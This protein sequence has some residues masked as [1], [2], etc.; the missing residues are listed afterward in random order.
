LIEFT[1]ERV[2]PG[3]VDPD[4]WNEHVA[5]YEF[6]ARLAEGRRVL[7]AGC[8][9][10]YGSARL[11]EVARSVV[12]V[13]SAADAIGYALR[14][15]AA[16]NLCFLQASCEALPLAS[17]SRDL[18]TAFEVIEHL[19]DWRAFL[20]EVERVLAPGGL[21]VI[22]TPNTDY[23]AESR[24]LTGP[25]PYHVH[26]FDFAGFAEALAARFPHVSLY[27]E[28]HVAAIAFEPAGGA[29]EGPVAL[30]RAARGTEAGWPHFFLA[31]CGASA[32]PEPRAFVYV[33]TTANV[34]REREVHI[35]KLETDLE[36]LRLAKQE[37]VE[38]FRTQN[39]ELDRSNRWA[40][41]LD[42][43]LAA[44][45]ARIVEVQ[46][47]L[48]ATTAGYET[49]LAELNEE[50]RRKTEWARKVEGELEK[51]GEELVK[52]IGLLDTAEKTVIE[53][54]NW[55]KELEGQLALVRGSRWVKLG[56]RFGLGPQ[57]PEV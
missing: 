57:L 1:G 8:G 54:T 40:A 47:E 19:A 35:D 24:K 18:V 31:V 29:E 36:G 27:L 26:E 55:A 41:E 12:A 45:Q 6:A 13:D 3:Q 39:A 14:T 15:Y 34:L 11:A 56:N 4:L 10:G 5:R 48:A 20:A 50:N 51:K 52:C 9:S 21:L 22:S 32:V 23:Y 38:M 42:E 30:E 49:K 25:N 43:K 37:L 2:I 46:D 17:R 33:P 44:A 7:D 28:N 53:R 16:T